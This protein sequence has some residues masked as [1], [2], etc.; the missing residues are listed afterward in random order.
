MWEKRKEEE[1]VTGD[2]REEGGPAGGWRG[3]G[4]GGAEVKQLGTSQPL[5]WGLWTA[6]WRPSLPGR[7]GGSLGKAADPRVPGQITPILWGQKWHQLKRSL[8]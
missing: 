3:G 6:R 4:V 5:P 2:G 8:G 1:E 7:T